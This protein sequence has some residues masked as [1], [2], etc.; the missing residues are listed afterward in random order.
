VLRAELLARARAIKALPGEYRLGAGAPHQALSPYD[1]SGECDC[2]GFVCW[3]LGIDR[4]QPT[5]AFLKKEIGHCWMNTDAI[6][7]DTRISAGLFLFPD[8]ARP[9]DLIV[10]PSLAY[11]RVANAKAAGPKI[12]HVGIL[13]GDRSVIHCSAGNMKAH[14]RAVWETDTEVFLR[15][16]YARA[17]RYVGLED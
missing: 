11:A 4:Y 2:S 17:A 8:K 3:A 16:P 15:V 13:T 7:A 1:Q 10:Y 6:V 9:G 5:L 14:G 12:G